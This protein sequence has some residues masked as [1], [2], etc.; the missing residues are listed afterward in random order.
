[1]RNDGR[2]RETSRKL[3]REGKR[4]FIPLRVSPLQPSPSV[5]LL[6]MVRDFAVWCKQDIG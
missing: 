1:M 5:L 4:L 2:K 6:E 3:V